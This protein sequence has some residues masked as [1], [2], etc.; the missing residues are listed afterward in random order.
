MDNQDCGVHIKAQFL[1]G[2]LKLEFLKLCLS[3]VCTHPFSLVWH[4]DSEHSFI[5]SSE[6]GYAFL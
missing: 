3:F 4:F 5:G 2:F 1:C 6:A